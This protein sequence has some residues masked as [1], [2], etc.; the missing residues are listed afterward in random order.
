M[1][2]LKRPYFEK[3]KKKKKQ[4]EKKEKKETRQ[5]ENPKWW[6]RQ[7]LGPKKKKKIKESPARLKTQKGGLGK[8]QG[9]RKE[10]EEEEEIGRSYQVG[11]LKMQPKKRIILQDE[12]LEVWFNR[13]EHKNNC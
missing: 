1:L 11:N 3:K 5:A 13:N 12:S 6:S 2:Q 4:K 8:G 10:E 7:K 9:E